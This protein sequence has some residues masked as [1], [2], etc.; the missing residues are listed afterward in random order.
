[1]G[2]G[3]LSRSTADFTVVQGSMSQ[4]NVVT[5]HVAIGSLLVGISVLLSTRLWRL[6]IEML[7]ESQENSTDME[8]TAP[9]E[10]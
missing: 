10:G 6:S 7:Q 3:D 2:I 1:M 8:N 9:L 4:S 5:A